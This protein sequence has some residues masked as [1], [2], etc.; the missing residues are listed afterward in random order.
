[1]SSFAIRSAGCWCPAILL[2]LVGATLLPMNVG[3]A[4]EKLKG[5]ELQWSQ[6]RGEDSNPVAENEMLPT[7]W[8]T[9]ENVE[10][11]VEIEGRGWSSPVVVGNQVFV[12]SVVTDGE[13]KPPQAGTEYSNEYVAELSKQGLSNEEIMEKVNQRDFELPEDVYLHYWLHCMDLETGKE[14]WKREFHE[15]HPPGGRHRKNSFVS[16][17]PAT[18]GKRVYVYATSLALFAFELNGELAWKTELP[19]HK[20][21]LEFGPGSSP[22]VVD[23]SVIV[24]FD[25]EEQSS[26]TAY[27]T[28]DGS[29][30][31][32]VERSVPEGAP[33]GL[34][35]SGWTTPLV[36]NNSLRTELVTVGPGLAISY[37]LDGAELWR[38]QGMTPAPA[39]GSITDGDLLFLN[40]GRGR[41]VYGVRAGASGDI[42]V[43]K[44]SDAGEFVSW[45]QPRIGTYIPSPVHYQGGLYFINDDGIISRLDAATGDV[46]YK[47]R[48]SDSKA[49]GTDFSASAWAYQNR[50]FFASEQGNVYVVQAGD[51]FELLGINR[52]QDWIMATPAIVGDRLLIR[53]GK[54]L[55]S[56]RG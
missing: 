6:F 50:V 2:L 35:K 20:V 32:Q 17:T 26:I 5:A 45:T 49:E 3:R 11:S 47:K 30:R 1:M 34:P 10:W 38:M 24:L 33:A 12:T 29:Q 25:N 16:E 39:A 48:L 15:G 55:Y 13:S 37:G 41:P 27:N 23:D 4:S 28:L 43:Q 44:D 40:A 9:E 7:S 18:D 51:E 14:L 53:T 46:T 8:S 31:W 19:K 42:T 21:Y 54:K 56:I 22:I 36:W 52:M